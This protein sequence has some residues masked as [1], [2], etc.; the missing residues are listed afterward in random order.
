MDSILGPNCH[1]HFNL[2]NKR[3]R[4]IDMYT[5]GRTDFSTVKTSTK[6]P[7]YLYSIG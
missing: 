2:Y 3:V 4:Y 1:L 6:N 5:Y 7:L